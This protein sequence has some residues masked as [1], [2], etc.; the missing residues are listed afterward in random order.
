MST[1]TVSIHEQADVPQPVQHGAPGGFVRHCNI[2]T[3]IAAGLVLAVVTYFVGSLWLVP[4]GTTT[5]NYVQVGNDALWAATFIAWVIG[6]M[7]GIG[8]FAGPI[9][10]SLGRDL[11]HADAEYLAGKDLG[12]A[13]YWKYTTDHK[14]VGL[15]YLVMAL[16]LFGVGGL[17]AM[18]IRTELGVTWKE[19][20]SPDFYNAIIGTH[21]IVMIIAMIIA[22]AGPLG[23]FILPIMIGARDM[24]FPRLN[25]LS[26]WLLFAA[27]PPLLISL[28][29]GGIRDGWSVYQPLSAQAPT[30]AIGYQVTII[31]F[32]FSTGIA[33]VNLITTTVTM[34]ARGM[35]WNRVPV[36]AIGII[37]SS[38]MGLIWFPMFQYSQ[39]LALSD[40]AFGSSFFNPVNGGSVWLYENLFWLLGHPEVYVV[41]I[42]ATAAMME[43]AVV[44]MRKP[45]FSYKI[46]VAGFAGV[47]GISA[48]V[49]VHHMY[50]TGWAPAA[51]YPFMLSTELISIPFGFLVLV[52][53]GTIWRGKAWTSLPMMAVYVLLWNKVV[54][55]ITGVY[56]SDTPVDQYMHGSMFVVAHFH[57]MLMGAGLFGAMGAIVY[58]FPKMTARMFDERIGSIGFWTA[59]FGFQLTFMSMF[60]AGLQGQ[61]RRVLQFDNAFNISNWLSTIGAYIIGIGMLIFLAAVITSWRSGVKAPANPWASTSLEWQTQTPVPLE[62]FPVLP[63]VTS[64]PYDYG[65]PDPYDTASSKD[66]AK[67]TVGAR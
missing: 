43:I 5:A 49:W 31:V 8:A 3:G 18:M 22:V 64:D 38:I 44:F 59:F 42:P 36:F 30:G 52:L 34:R 40:R 11:T 57:F 35:T 56:L 15:Q 6:F 26:F 27:V 63:V 14:V 32:A 29:M 33:A 23:N 4:W 66:Q 7:A 13:R 55:G 41:V 50:M 19:V 37:A 47:V 21:G 54:G 10:W 51:N 20:F 67:Q 48:I 2:L 25:A 62:N 61:P 39:V 53:L 58:W 1:A 45:L 17:L 65:V 16:V 28:A 24:A 9:R 46:A 60:V 12:R